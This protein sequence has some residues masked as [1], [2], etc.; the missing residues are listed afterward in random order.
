[1]RVWRMRTGIPITLKPA[2]RRR[3]KVLVRDRNTPHKHVWRAE[4][5]LLSGDGIGTNEI[6]RR[7]GKSKTCVWRW[8]ERFMREGMAG[9]MHDK[10]RPPG[11]KPLTAEIKAKVLAKTTTETPPN[12][13]HWS[14]RAMAKA[15]GLS[16]TSVQRIWNEAGLKPHLV[17]RFKVSNDP[18]FEAKV[19]DVVGL[20]MNPPDRALV[21]CVDEKSQ[22]QALDR[23]QPGLPLK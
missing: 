15:M 5:V 18:D 16:H 6:M 2:D 1:M 12:A 13:T 4:I 20:Y 17:K 21:L 9:L 11:R 19:I 8:Q 22:I 10:T 23:T 3:L 14:A 7:S